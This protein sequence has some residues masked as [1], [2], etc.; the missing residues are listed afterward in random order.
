MQSSSP[1]SLPVAGSGHA[2][3]AICNPSERLGPLSRPVRT[4]TV[5][6]GR[7]RP[8]RCVLSPPCR[9]VLGKGISSPADSSLWVRTFHRLEKRMRPCGREGRGAPHLADSQ[10]PKQW[11]Q[12]CLPPVFRRG[13]FWVPSL[14]VFF[15]G[16][17]SWHFVGAG[18]LSF[19][20]A[21]ATGVLGDQSGDETVFQFLFGVPTTL[22]RRASGG[23]P[24]W[25]APQGFFHRGVNRE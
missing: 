1:A 19:L 23:L 11:S 14:R 4:H 3:G 5:V 13:V 24:G 2:P 9:F 6:S 20:A 15:R 7:A 8:S 16:V 25:P 17:V 10:R 21:L 18:R 22:P 12:A